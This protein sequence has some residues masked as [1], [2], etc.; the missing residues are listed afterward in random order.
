MSNFSELL[1][2]ILSPPLQF[3]RGESSMSTMETPECVKY[4]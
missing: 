1:S 3:G 2:P 4:G